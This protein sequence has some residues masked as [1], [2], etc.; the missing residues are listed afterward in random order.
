MFVHTV[1][2]V[3][4]IY[5]LTYTCIPMY[6]WLLHLYTYAYIHMYVFMYVICVCMYIH[7][8]MSAYIHILINTC[9]HICIQ[10]HVCLPISIPLW[11]IDASCIH[12]HTYMN[13][14]IHI[15][16]MGMSMNAVGMSIH[17]F[18]WNFYVLA[19][20][21]LHYSIFDDVIMLHH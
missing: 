13:A 8:Y 14:Y 16:V 5:G 17:P 20:K 2:Y 7:L 21:Y 4:F 10:I 3:I 12:T 1:I 11:Y 18:Q 9:T 6:V 19:G 15:F